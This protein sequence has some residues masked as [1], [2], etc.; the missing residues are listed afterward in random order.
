M[1]ARDAVEFLH[2][3]MWFGMLEPPVKASVVVHVER[4]AAR[5]P[6]VIAV[7]DWAFSYALGYNDAL[8]DIKRA[9]LVNLATSLN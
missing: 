8:W 7:D 9:D 6:D 4:Y 2:T 5:L 1:S 3:R